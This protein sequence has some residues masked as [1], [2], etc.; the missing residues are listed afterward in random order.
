MYADK[1]TNSMQ[2]TIDATNYRREKQL[3][4]N[5]ENNIIPTAIIKPTRE[6]IG[7]EF[8]SGKKQT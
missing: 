4:Y 1:M 5:T 2:R 6:I 8:R 7:Y 3:S